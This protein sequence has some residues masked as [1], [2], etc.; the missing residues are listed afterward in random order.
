[1]QTSFILLTSHSSSSN[2][3]ES[4]C[5]FPENVVRIC[6]VRLTTSWLLHSTRISR[7]LVGVVPV[8]YAPSPL[9]PDTALSIRLRGTTCSFAGGDEAPLLGLL[10]RQ[11]RHESNCNSIVVSLR[12][13]PFPFYPTHST[14][15]PAVLLLAPFPFWRLSGKMFELLFCPTAI[16]G[17]NCDLLL[18][19]RDS[20]QLSTSSSSSPSLPAS[21]FAVEFSESSSPSSS[22]SSW[23]FGSFAFCSDTY[24]TVWQM[25]HKV[26]LNSLEVFNEMLRFCLC[27]RHRHRLAIAFRQ[28]WTESNWNWNWN[29]NWNRV[30]PLPFPLPHADLTLINWPSARVGIPVERWNV[31]VEHF[32]ALYSNKTRTFHNHK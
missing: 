1:M 8:P 7:D 14:T 23:S 11:A 31:T 2:W 3:S 10:S 28:N 17:E 25:L 5:K 21:S 20:H 6:Q 12:H 24:H 4:M 26:L 22:S 27:H 18:S 15:L 32:S 13:L 16:C 9:C 30:S 29:W 19:A